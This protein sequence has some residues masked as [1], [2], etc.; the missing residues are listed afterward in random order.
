MSYTRLS[1]EEYRR[2]ERIVVTMADGLQP[3]INLSPNTCVL[4]NVVSI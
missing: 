2:K 3:D 4:L 1:P